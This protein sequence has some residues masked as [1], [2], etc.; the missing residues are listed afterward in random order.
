MKSISIYEFK[1]KIETD[2]D[3]IIVDVRSPEEEVEGIIENS[4][5]INIMEPSFPA[6][7]MDL[8]K[9]KCYYVYCRS[10]GR[11]ASACMYM[12]KLGLN[13]INVEGGIMAWN[14]IS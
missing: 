4:L 14:Q 13:A 2:K 6:K 12:E 11:S 1:A 5:R 7:V 9:S 3:A 10:G 8:D